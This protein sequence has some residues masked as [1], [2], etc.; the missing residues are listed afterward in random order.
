MEGR[1]GEGEGRHVPA[2]DGEACGVCFDGGVVVWVGGVC[3]WGGG[4][5]GV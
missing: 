4:G 2:C 1:D 5:G 3:V